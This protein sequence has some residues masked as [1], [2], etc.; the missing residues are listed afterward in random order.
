M[1]RIF[2]LGVP[3]AADDES[4][5]GATPIVYS[6]YRQVTAA[7]RAADGAQ[8]RSADVVTRSQQCKESEKIFHRTGSR[9]LSIRQTCARLVALAQT[10]IWSEG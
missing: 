9:A 3:L 8:E 6:L 5:K 7:G 2:S 4:T 10:F 1:S